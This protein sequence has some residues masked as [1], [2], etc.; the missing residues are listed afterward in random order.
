MTQVTL[1][2]GGSEEKTVDAASIKI[3]DL[4]HIAEWLDGEATLRKMPH[5]AKH[6]DMIRDCWTLT[7]SLLRHAQKG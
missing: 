7:H 4:W 1:N 5:L 6:A 3:P 2:K